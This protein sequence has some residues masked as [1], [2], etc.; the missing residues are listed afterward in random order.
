MNGVQYYRPR[1]PSKA[2]RQTLHHLHV[3]LLAGSVEV[4][5]YDWKEQQ[6]VAP[7]NIPGPGELEPNLASEGYIAIPNVGGLPVWL[8]EETGISSD[9]R[10]ELGYFL[11]ASCG[12][13]CNVPFKDNTCDECVALEQQGPPES[14]CENCGDTTTGI[15][16]YCVECTDILNGHPDID[17][18]GLGNLISGVKTALEVVEDNFNTNRFENAASEARD[19]VRLMLFRLNRYY[20]VGRR[21]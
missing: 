3:A 11:C 16:R 13:T 1:Y 9:W 7:V 18:E 15:H 20:D 17:G 19:L 4:S 10:Y 21:S 12:K 5:L 14:V 2:T 8:N 6:N